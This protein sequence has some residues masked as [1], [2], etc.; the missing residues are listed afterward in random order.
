MEVA[1]GDRLVV[2]GHHIGDPDRGAL[3]LT[4]EGKDGGPPYLVQ[5]EDD[6]HESLYFPGSDAKVEHYPRRTENA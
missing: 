3:V 1:V 4:V 5:W 2:R 6:G